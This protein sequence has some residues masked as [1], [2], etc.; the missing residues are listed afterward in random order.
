[1][2]IRQLSIF[3]QNSRGQMADAVRTIADANINIKAMSVADSRDFGILRLIVS[4]NARAVSLLSENTLVKLTEVVAVRME[5]IEGS[6]YK[7]L[8]VLAK[9]EID[10]EYSY[11]FTASKNPS[12]YAVFRVDDIAKAEEVLTANGFTLL[13]ESDL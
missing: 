6:L 13:S 5:D 12:P 2:A 11:S 7:I 9:A 8:K 1:M 10:V 4:D 3:I